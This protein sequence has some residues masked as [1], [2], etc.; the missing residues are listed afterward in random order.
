M[1]DA[2]DKR[3]EREK[4]A[5]SIVKRRNIVYTS[6]EELERR[7]QEEK[8]Q[9][10]REAAEEMVK[11]LKED[12]HNKQAMQIQRLLAEQQMLEQQLKTGMDA[13]GKHPMDDVTQERV[14]AI[15]SEKSKQL[16]DIIAAHNVEN[17]QEDQTLEPAVSKN[18]EPHGTYT[19]EGSA[20]T[21]I[22]DATPVVQSDL[23]DMEV[24][25]PEEEGDIS[26]E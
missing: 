20:Q 19:E 14:E 21:D 12:E 7:Q 4:I 11:K 24:L 17:R 26:Y 10:N 15:L 8:R 23:P 6:K 18:H 16:Q 1:K 13:T 3:N 5:K 25:L 9:E 2:I 22:Q